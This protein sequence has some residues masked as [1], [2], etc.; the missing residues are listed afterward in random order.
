MSMD[1]FWVDDATQIVSSINAF[2]SHFNLAQS[3]ASTLNSYEREGQIKTYKNKFTTVALGRV[4]PNDTVIKENRM[5]HQKSRRKTL[6]RTLTPRGLIA[7][8]INMRVAQGK[9]DLTSLYRFFH[10]PER[11]KLHLVKATMLLML[12][13]SLDPV[14]LVSKVFMPKRIT[15]CDSLLLKMPIY[16]KYGRPSSTTKNRWYISKRSSTENMAETKT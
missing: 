4:K 2:S 7:H 16:W 10:L 8:N 13:Y 3:E 11:Q 9:A 12:T 14:H 1:I 5:Q 6:S 15:H